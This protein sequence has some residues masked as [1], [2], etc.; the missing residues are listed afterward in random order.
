MAWPG[1]GP[2]S[3]GTV[4]ANE[5]LTDRGAQVSDSMSSSE[6][7]WG[8]EPVWGMEIGCWCG[9]VGGR[10]RRV[11]ADGCALTAPSVG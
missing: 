5:W 6:R 2:V 4:P 10:R 9:W 11:C 1:F 3:S 7:S 8:C